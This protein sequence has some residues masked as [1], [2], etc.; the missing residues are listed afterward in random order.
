M[1]EDEV[2]TITPPRLQLSLGTDGL[3]SAQVG[4]QSICRALLYVTSRFFV[5][6]LVLV[7]YFFVPNMVVLMMITL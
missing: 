7:F 2:V 6:K 1:V 3:L 5:H 4:D